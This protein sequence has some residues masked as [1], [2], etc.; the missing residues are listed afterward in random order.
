MAYLN[1]YLGTQSG[2]L[3]IQRRVFWQIERKVYK[4]GN[5]TDIRPE[6]SNTYG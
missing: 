6:S 3:Q 4:L 1:I 5:N 2:E